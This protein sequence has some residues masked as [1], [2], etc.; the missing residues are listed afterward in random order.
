M[1]TSI[2]VFANVALAG[3]ADPLGVSVSPSSFFDQDNNC[4]LDSQLITAS[5]SGG[6]PSYSYAWTWQSGGGG[7]TILSP[8]SSTTRIR[9]TTGGAKSGVL[10]MTV[11]DQEPDTATDTCSVNMECGLL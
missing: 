8:T 5:A 6:E 4:P 11:T 1:S 3:G 7:L 2:T 9:V 10:L